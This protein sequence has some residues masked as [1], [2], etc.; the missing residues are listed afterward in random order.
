LGIA[1]LG[2]LL[3]IQG[4]I[5]RPLWLDEALQAKISDAPTF[6][7]VIQRSAALDLHPPGFSVAAHAAMRLLGSDEWALRTPS[8]VAGVLTVPLAWAVGRAWGD[9]R[10]AT[11]L[12]LAA[13]VCP[14][15]VAYAR[16]A[17]P[18]AG[19][20]AW[21][22]GLLWAAGIHRR[23]PTAASTAALTTCAVG[24]LL[25]QYT[26]G[27]V[28]MG[29][30]GALAIHRSA[31]RG[32]WTAA[33]AT[34]IAGATLAWTVLRPQ[35][36]ERSDIA[37]HLDLSA[38]TGPFELI[39]Y[40]AVGGGS[41]GWLIGLV[42]LP[43]VARTVP[44]SLVWVAVLPAGLLYGLFLA[45]LHPFGGI[46]QCLVVT[47]GLL[48]AGA[49]GH[50]GLGRALPG[51]LAV[52]LAVQLYRFPGVPVWDLPQLAETLEGER[53]GEAVWVDPRLGLSWARY[54]RGIDAT[55]GTWTHSDLPAASPLWVVTVENGPSPARGHPVKRLA[56]EGVTATLWISE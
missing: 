14:P 7:D 4:V 2:A 46:R 22:L 9:R 12:A 15:W 27:V 37:G 49:H 41:G 33:L 21:T 23:T 11:T 50:Y 29:V 28:A 8:I 53:A 17:R 54:G 34:L 3:R 32:V 16:E 10:L 48:L 18:Y 43:L 31:D 42:L 19:A 20:I 44:Q 39:G 51:G 55:V 36:A 45:G 56:A 47:P 30:L 25:W 38:I 13:A 35:L 1:I 52:A 5:S 6:A 24:G 40:C 26:S